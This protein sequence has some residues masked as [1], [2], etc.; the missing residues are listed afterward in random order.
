MRAQRGLL[1]P[2]RP[3]QGDGGVPRPGDAVHR[4]AAALAPPG[5]LR[6]HRLAARL[7]ARR[8]PLPPVRGAE[9]RAAAGWGIPRLLPLEHRLR[10]SE[11]VSLVEAL[12]WQAT[13]SG[14]G[15]F[16]LDNQFWQLV[17]GTWLP[18][19]AVLAVGGAA[20]VAICLL[21][22]IRA[23][24][25]LAAGLL[26]PPP[27]L[28]PRPRG[29]V[30][31]FYVLAV[32]PFLCL[33]VGVAVAPLL[34]RLPAALGGGVV[35]VASPLAARALLDGRLAAAPLRRPRRRGQPGGHRLGREHLPAQSRIVMY[36]SPWVDLR[37]PGPD[38]PAFPDAHSHWK[39]ALDP[40]IRSGVF[41]DD[42][43][44]VDYLL[45][46]SSLP[47]AFR[48]TGNTVADQAL[49]NASLV[50]RWEADGETIELWKVNRPGATEVALLADRPGPPHGPLRAP[51]GAGSPGRHRGLGEPGLRHAARRLV[52]RPAGL[53]PHLG[54][55]A[56]SNL[57]NTQGAALLAVEGRRR[58][59][60]PRGG[61]RGRG[62]RPRPADGRA[63]L[64]RPGPGRGRPADGAGY[65]GPRGGDRGRPPPPRRRGLGD[66]GAGG[67]GQPQLLRALR[68]PHLQG[69]RSRARLVL[70][71]RQRLRRPLR[72]VERHPGSR[73]LGRA[74]AG[75]GGARP[76]HRPAGAP[77][78]AKAA[79]PPATASTLPA[80]TGGWPSICAGP[81]M[82]GPG[83]TSPRPDSCGTRWNARA[84]SAPSTP[85]TAR[86][87]SAP[88][89]SSARPGRS[90]P[91][92]PSTRPWPTGCT[93][94]ASSA[95]AVY[96][97]SG[98]DG[99]GGQRR[100]AF[101]ASPDDLYAQD[102]GW[103]ATALYAGALPN[104][105]SA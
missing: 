105:W 17:R 1:R 82:A 86:S 99:A 90:P 102:W 26:G 20:A 80:P 45:M 2:R 66:R 11:H 24:R 64:E 28:L 72:R 93:P 13:R 65:L 53:R 40:A 73:A 42:W 30:F 91:C 67:G 25:A 103:F 22:G 56:D 55:D 21:R 10:S 27:A 15:M 6:R 61:G 34:R 77:A 85:A 81:A 44:T 48:D 69:S 18:R 58:G 96:A 74:A 94:A 31:D 57:L 84:R 97:P 104:L 16:N 4:L 76:R 87:R 46:T 38:G 60:R 9:G 78:A 41:Q 37:E 50:K 98:P 75:L 88:P 33:C 71:A 70:P 62:R 14:G 79:T 39:V 95:A 3:E 59:G 68:L 5:A 23:R 12:Q 29:L 36:D 92:S 63:A 83:P 89:A 8:Q 100:R 49:Q 51:G 35:G 43:R 7:S 47:Q 54:L 101:W 52:G 19:D 32:V